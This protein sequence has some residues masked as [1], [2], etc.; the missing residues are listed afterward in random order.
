MNRH[1]LF[2]VFLATAPALSAVFAEEPATPRSSPPNLIANSSFELGTPGFA[3]VRGLYVYRNPDLKY[4]P[5]V[6]D[7]TT[8]VHGKT[9][10]KLGN[11][12]GD[13][14]QLY[15]PEVRLVPGAPSLPSYVPGT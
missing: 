4:T 9:S 7:I 5:P 10:L 8:K 1:M 3:A 12:Y 2:A 15:A 11:I 13:Y 14:V 6:L